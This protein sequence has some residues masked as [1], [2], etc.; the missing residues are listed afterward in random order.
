MPTPLRPE[1]YKRLKGRLGPV[2]IVNEGDAFQ[3]N[4]AWNP[5]TRRLQLQATWP[6]EYYTT[7]CVFCNDTRQR[8]WINHRWGLYVK[9]LKS[10]NLW[11]AICYNENCLSVPGRALQL[12]DLIFNDF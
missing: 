12:K 7:N 5:V 3:G 9:E 8:L 4:V 1:L 10:D 6:G 11:L 2:T